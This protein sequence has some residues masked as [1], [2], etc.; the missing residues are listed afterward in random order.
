M[1]TVTVC[2]QSCASG[3][4]LSNVVPFNGAEIFLTLPNNICGVSSYQTDDET[5]IFKCSN[6]WKIETKVCSI[7]IN[8]ISP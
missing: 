5:S 8:P 6:L 4:D 3:D 2:L 1:G 7:A